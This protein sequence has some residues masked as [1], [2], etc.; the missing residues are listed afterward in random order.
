MTHLTYTLW[1]ALLVAA[2]M[3]MLGDRTHRERVYVAVYWFC[4][5]MASVVAGAWIMHWAHG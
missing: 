1:L 2:A 3:A 5:A 4:S